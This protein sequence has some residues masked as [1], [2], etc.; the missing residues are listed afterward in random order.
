MPQQVDNA[1]IMMLD[2]IS[3]DD[4]GRKLRVAG[5]MLTYDAESA[6]VLLHDATSALLV[7]VSLCVDADVLLSTKNATDRNV[8]HCWALERKGL[9]WVVGYLER[10]DS[11]LPIPTLP[12][13][14]APPD[15]DPSLVMRAV[16]VAPARDLN[17]AQLRAVLAEMAEVP[18]TSY[19]V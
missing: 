18:L 17:T 19:P 4:V 12:A 15:I 8:D 7:D 3:E 13:Y 10:V 6:L 2:C 1:S 5:R 14:L 16:V 11:Q 9:V